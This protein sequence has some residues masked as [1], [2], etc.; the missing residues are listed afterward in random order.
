MCLCTGSYNGIAFITTYRKEPSVMSTNDREHCNMFGRVLCGINDMMYTW[1][2]DMSSATYTYVR[3]TRY[4][5][6]KTDNEHCHIFD[7]VTG[8]RMHRARLRVRMCNGI[9]FITTYRKIFFDVNEK[10]QAL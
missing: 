8:Y 6:Q 7:G 2:C 10:L 9:A 1:V 3:G 5:Q 4:R